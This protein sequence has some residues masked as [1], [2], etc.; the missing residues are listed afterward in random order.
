MCREK[1]MTVI[2][3]KPL[4]ILSNCGAKIELFCECCKNISAFFKNASAFDL[5]RLG[6]CI[7]TLRCF[8]QGFLP[9]F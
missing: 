1:G 7:K 9:A 5:K 4:C 2:G 3:I 8:V 6:V